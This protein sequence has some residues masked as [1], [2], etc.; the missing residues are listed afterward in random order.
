MIVHSAMSVELW[1][2]LFVNSGKME[3]VKEIHVIYGMEIW[4]YR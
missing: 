3:H 1:V 4:S 2:I